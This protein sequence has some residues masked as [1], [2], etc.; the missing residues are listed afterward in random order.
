MSNIRFSERSVFE[1]RNFTNRAYHEFVRHVL[2]CRMCA[3]AVCV[4]K[5]LVSSGQHCSKL[6]LFINGRLN[7]S[8]Y[9]SAQAVLNILY[10]HADRDDTLHHGAAIS[11]PILIA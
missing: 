9:C 7:G 2:K 8:T 11:N 1:F 10:L 3:I 5:A 6:S 4:V